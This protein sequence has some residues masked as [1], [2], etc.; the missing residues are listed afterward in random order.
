MTSG[1]LSALSRARKNDNLP[2]G[3]TDR[4]EVSIGGFKR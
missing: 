2:V 4:A 3:S 1:H